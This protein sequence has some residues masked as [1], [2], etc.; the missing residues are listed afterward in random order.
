MTSGELTL[1][2]D[3]SFLYKP[4][5]DFAGTTTFSYKANDGELDTDPLTVTFTINEDHD[6]PLAVD[7]LYSL[8]NKPELRVTAPIISML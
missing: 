2:P 3:G 1:H 6:N 4:E 8:D 5:K 7:D